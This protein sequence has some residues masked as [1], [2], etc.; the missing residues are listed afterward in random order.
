MLIEDDVWVTVRYRLF[1]SQGDALEPSER[2]LTYLQGGYGAVFPRIE[3]ALAGHG[4]GYTTSVYL[5]PED[6]FGDYDAERVVLVPRADLPDELEIG[7]TFD[8]VPGDGADPDDE[9]LYVVTDITDEAVVL[10]GNHPLAG[11]SLRFD[12]RVTEVRAASAEEVER[13]RENA[14][15]MAAEDG[16]GDG[17]DDE[18]DREDDAD[19]DADDGD[20]GD[21][22]RG[23]GS[24]EVRRLH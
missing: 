1:D 21:G 18:D 24:R 10:D 13:E 4:A 19:D 17:D 16:D 2:E 5:E 11:M 8:G 20:R 9:D 6:S 7:M 22:D 12:L 15:S 23:D 3:E 14:R